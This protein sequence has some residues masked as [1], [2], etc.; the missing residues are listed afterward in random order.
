MA[1]TPPGHRKE[2]SMSRE[3]PIPVAPSSRCERDY[4]VRYGTREVWYL[5]SLFCEPVHVYGWDTVGESLQER[6]PIST[7]LR[8][9]LFYRNHSCIV[10]HSEGYLVR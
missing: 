5:A 3:E 2:Q 9:V 4:I 7:A 10:A 1:A 8:G 6:N